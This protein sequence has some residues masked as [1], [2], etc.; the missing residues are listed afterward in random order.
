MLYQDIQRPAKRKTNL[1]NN[2]NHTFRKKYN[3]AASEGRTDRNDSKSGCDKN[4][5]TQS[6]KPA[7][8]KKYSGERERYNIPSNEL[9]G[10]EFQ[11]N[12]KSIAYGGD[13]VGEYEGKT[14]YVP[15]TLPG[16]TVIARIVDSRNTIIQARMVKVIKEA[17]YYSK[18][19]CPYFGV[20]GGCDL[21]NMPYGKQVEFKEKTVKELMEKEGGLKSPP[22]NTAV[23]YATPLNYRNRAEYRPL[24]IDN[25]FTL[26]F[27]KARSHDIIGVAKCLLLHPQINILAGIITE[28]INSNMHAVS[29]YNEDKGSGYLR[30]VTIRVNRGGTAL[31]TFV[32]NGKEPKQFILRAAEKLGQTYGVA[33]VILNYNIDGETNVFGGKEKILFGKPHI[34]E[35]AAGVSF[36]LGNKAFFQVNA[37]M[38]EK[39]AGFVNT[40]IG[41]G[42]A[43]L[44]LYG[45]VGA[46]TLPS[47]KKFGAIT[48]IESDWDASQNLRDILR[49]N[50]INNVSV[51]NARAE[52]AIDETMTRK[53]FDAAVIDPPRSGM[54]PRVIHALKNHPVDKLIYISCNP[55]SFAR[56]IAELK[57][58]YHLDEMT[59]LDQ[60]A[61]TY[62][63]EVMAE[64][65]HKT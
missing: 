23:S 49:W 20:C 47:H 19:E 33:G 58:A 63:I 5:K 65:S 53:R 50:K 18:P 57:G 45:G 21:M 52:E 34:I 41:Q 59:P 24:I 1:K 55:S 44:D 60:F 51:I 16:S 36:K 11:I 12:I 22:M 39:M 7:Y 9:R 54:H 43:V 40:K 31:I 64:L 25:K 2:R 4:K 30:H 42:A 27:H 62:H 37:D 61:Q 15:Y 8:K 13:G 32:V 38:M 6:F 48:V 35:T 28:T 26:G 10:R 17:S 14:V 3:P 56:D 46:L 29:A